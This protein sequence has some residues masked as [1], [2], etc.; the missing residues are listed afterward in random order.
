MKYLEAY[1]HHNGER[2]WAKRDLFE[3]LTDI[4]V[5]PSLDICK[6]STSLI[7]AHIRSQLDQEGW[8]GE[9]RI[10]QSYDLTVFSMKDDLA[11]QI[12][13]G[14]VSRGAYD[15]MKLQYLY[16]ANK[17]EAAAIAVPSSSA[18]QK[19]GS[20]IANFNRLMNEL[21]LF[22]RVISIPLLLISFE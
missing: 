16:A 4:F 10:D 14:N 15:L 12:Q 6:G 5:A 11:F 3:W 19:I 9:V 17:I 7:R 8:S 22:D 20:N 18:A 13:T 1:S 21:Q 2:E